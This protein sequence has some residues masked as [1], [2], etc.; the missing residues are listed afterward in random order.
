[1]IRPPGLGGV[2][3]SAADDGDL[4]SDWQ[5]RSVVSTELG[6]SDQWGTVNQVHGRKIVEVASPGGNGDA[7]ALWTSTAGIPLAVF[8]ADCYGTVIK[9]AGAVGVAHAGWRGANLGIVSE[10]IGVM[11]AAG[12]SAEHV[13]IGPGIMPCCFE[14]G[15]EVAE[16]FPKATST[17]SWGTVS[18]DLVAQIRASIPVEV[19]V[20]AGGQCTMHE[21]GW[22]SHRGTGTGDRMAAIAWI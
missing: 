19:E 21:P 10:L 5:A 7:D 18:V 11:S 20:W 22:F 2:A 15:A 8:T 4:R 13:A 9:A 14:V 1:M 12:F 6:I 3:F 16:L 17:T